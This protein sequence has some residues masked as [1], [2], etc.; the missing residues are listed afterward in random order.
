MTDEPFGSKEVSGSE[1]ML[2]RARERAAGGSGGSGA[3]PGGGG[4]GGPRFEPCPSCARLIAAW[5]DPCPYC[6]ERT[7]FQQWSNGPAYPGRA[8][9]SPPVVR[10]CV[11][12]GQRVYSGLETCPHCGAAQEA[13]SPWSG[14]GERRLPSPGPCRNGGAPLWIGVV[15]VVA[16]LVA[17]GIWGWRSLSDD[18]YSFEGVDDPH[19][20]AFLSGVRE[21]MEESGI[22]GDSVDCMFD[23]LE[24]GGYFDVVVDMDLTDPAA[25][26][27]V[28]AF[29]ADSAAAADLPEEL[30]TFMEG[31]SLSMTECLSVEEMQL[32]ASDGP[33][34]YGDDPGGLDL[35]WSRCQAADMA[36]CDMLFW[37]SSFGSEYEEYGATCG[38]LD[39][40]AS[41]YCIYLNGG[42]PNLSALRSE[43][44]TGGFAACDLLYSVSAVGSEY[45]DFALTCGGRNEADYMGC[46][47]RYGLFE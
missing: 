42:Q 12:C 24:A 31:L 33:Q 47:F 45:E 2:R 32:A 16:G 28:N 36:A 38:G 18:D 10:R 21:G 6:R 9:E 19:T 43:C 39:P 3:G 30:Q 1:E 23:Y 5:A 40:T 25:I 46:V 4:A 22:D 8:P 14:G 11:Q 20:E 17:A 37:N 41:E 35:L 26:A 15:V 29:N 44:A 34:S 13:S 27:A 7:G